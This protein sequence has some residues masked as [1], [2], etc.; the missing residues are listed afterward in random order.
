MCINLRR[1]VTSQRVLGAATISTDMVELRSKELHDSNSTC[2]MVLAFR[3]A[4]H[5]CK[6][7][8]GVWVRQHQ[9]PLSHNS[10]RTNG[11]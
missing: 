9:L 8:D 11:V 6:V 1:I 5:G 3:Y 10:H 4:D 7:N 2:A